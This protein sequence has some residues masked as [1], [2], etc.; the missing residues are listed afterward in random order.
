MLL[1]TAISIE[2]V[3]VSGL[4]LALISG[5]LPKY[6]H[7]R[8]LGSFPSSHGP[9]SKRGLGGGKLPK[10]LHLPHIP[11]VATGRE[12]NFL[13][14][15]MRKQFN[16]THS[17]SKG[18]GGYFGGRGCYGK[19]KDSTVFIL[20]ASLKS[21][22]KIP[23]KCCYFLWFLLHPHCFTSKVIIYFKRISTNQN[24]N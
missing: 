14:S 3:E 21:T 7:P 6:R 22:L 19:Y 20:F 2:S 17:I 9:Q 13:R 18:D 8:D 24:S 1:T 11:P 12:K 16:V 5:S 23:L 4:L 15:M 10:T